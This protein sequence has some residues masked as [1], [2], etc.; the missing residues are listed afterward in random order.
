MRSCWVKFLTVGIAAAAA[1]I[2]AGRSTPAYAHEE[3]NAGP[4][5]SGE[6]IGAVREAEEWRNA[7]DIAFVN[8]QW[9]EAYTFYEKAAMTFPGT[10]H[11]QIA[12][13]RG[14]NSLYHMRHA[15]RIPPGEDWLR[16]IYDSVTW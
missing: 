5:W 4:S 12:T 6:W 15:G 13:W 16:E 9:I 2:V 7:G 10:P 1:A 8:K 3:E 14:N 11:G